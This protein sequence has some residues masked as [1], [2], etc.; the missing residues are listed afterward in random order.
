MRL[1]IMFLLCTFPAVAIA[2]TPADVLKSMTGSWHSVAG[3][4]EGENGST[5]TTSQKLVVTQA[6][7]VTFSIQC[8]TN[9]Q[10]QQQGLELTSVVMDSNGNP[11]GGKN[12]QDTEWGFGTAKTHQIQTVTLLGGGNKIDFIYSNQQP[13]W[14]N[15]VVHLTLAR[16]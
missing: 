11:K 3:S 5:C 1:I 9:F 4:V 8:S 2:S 12:V 10:I 16:D 13:G 6:A 15:T 7:K 14:S